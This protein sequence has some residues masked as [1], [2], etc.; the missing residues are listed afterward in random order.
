MYVLKISDPVISLYVSSAGQI[1]AEESLFFYGDGVSTSNYSNPAFTPSFKSD[2][3]AN[4]P[5]DTTTYCQSNPECIFDYS[6]SGDQAV[7]SA[8]LQANLAF[9]EKEN[10]ACMLPLLTIIPVTFVLLPF[11]LFSNV[12]ANNICCI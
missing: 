4:A 8:T 10:K 7:A 1:T 12:S 2:I 11:C 3:V 9:I 6:V 5:N